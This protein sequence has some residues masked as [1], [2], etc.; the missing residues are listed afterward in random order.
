MEKVS[1]W[2]FNSGS[3]AHDGHEWS[4]DGEMSWLQPQAMNVYRVDMAVPPP[5][6]EASDYKVWFTIFL[7]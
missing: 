7:C 6:M 4:G 2:V 5:N 1:Q 3:R